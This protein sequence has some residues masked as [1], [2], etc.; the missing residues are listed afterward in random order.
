MKKRMGVEALKKIAKIAVAKAISIEAQSALCEATYDEGWFP[1]ECFATEGFYN[2][3]SA[4]AQSYDDKWDM[5]V[6]EPN[7]MSYFQEHVGIIPVTSSDLLR[8]YGDYK[9]FINHEP[10]LSPGDAIIYNAKKILFC[11]R[12]GN[13]FMLLSQKDE[14]GRFVSKV[15]FHDI[16][17]STNL[18]SVDSIEKAIEAFLPSFKGSITT[19][20]FQM[21]DFQF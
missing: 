19:S 1:F 18:G 3:I 17:H 5:V 8:D 7:I 4:L 11:S 9:S 16:G 13:W 14:L 10:E 2:F 15:S 12:N 6:L 21:S 20:E